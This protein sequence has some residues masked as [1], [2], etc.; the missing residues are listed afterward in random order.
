MKQQIIIIWRLAESDRLRRW[1][2]RRGYPNYYDA[3]NHATQTLNSYFTAC[4]I[5]GRNN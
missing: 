2:T 3:I 4:V 5:A 1:I